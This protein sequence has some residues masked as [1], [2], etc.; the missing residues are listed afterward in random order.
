MESD[1]GGASLRDR[2][3][4]ES[5]HNLLLDTAINNMPTGL[6]MF[7]A[8]ERIVSQHSVEDGV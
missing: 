6:V 2:A 3:P 4:A 5:D 7:D 8:S 1:G